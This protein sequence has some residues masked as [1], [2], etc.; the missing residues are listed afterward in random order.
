MILRIGESSTGCNKRTLPGC[1]LPGGISRDQLLSLMN[2][3]KYGINGALDEHFGISVAE[4]V[5]AGC[6]VFVPNGGGQTEIVGTP[7]LIYNGVEDAVAKITSVLRDDSAQE[8][9]LERLGHQGELFSTL[10]FC[11]NMER[12]VDRFFG[13]R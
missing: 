11:Q 4:M 7:E 3:Y 6:I 5:K 9:V 10:A 13:K 1:P 12:V 2:Q 8:M